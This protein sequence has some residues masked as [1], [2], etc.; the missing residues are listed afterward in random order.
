MSTHK[1]SL[2][3]LGDARP[4]IIITLLVVALALIIPGRT[5]ADPI[6]DPSAIPVFCFRIT[7]IVRV[8]GDPGND[9]FRIEF[10]VLN[11]SHDS[12][13]GVYIALNEG[14]GV[15]TVID[16]HPFF[17]GAEIDSDG[18]PLVLLQTFA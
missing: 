12:A 7:D 8:A 9:S 10:E 11:W 18:R 5:L 14:T 3:N 15:G 6:P 13:F 1:L 17:V 4:G 2:M 16:S